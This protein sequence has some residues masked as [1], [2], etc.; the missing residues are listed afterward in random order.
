MR[1]IIR[2]L[3][4]DFASAVFTVLKEHPEKMII[5]AIEMAAEQPAP[6]MY[7][8]SIEVAARYIR[9]LMCG[10]ELPISN[11]N[12]E[13]MY[14]ELHR[15]YVAQLPPSSHKRHVVD[16]DLLIKVCEEPAPSFYRDVTYLRTL[17]YKLQRRKL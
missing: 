4:E 6:R 9:T 1:T 8:N 3:A 2:Q 15:R 5:E 14:K 7:I 13:A 10:E 11:S 16:Y 17:F 12:I